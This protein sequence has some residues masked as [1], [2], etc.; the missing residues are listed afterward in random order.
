MRVQSTLALT[1]DLL[2]GNLSCQKR[3]LS[4]RYLVCLPKHLPPAKPNDSATAECSPDPYRACVGRHPC[5]CRCLEPCSWLGPCMCASVFGYSRWTRRVDE[6]SPPSKGPRNAQLVGRYPRSAA[7]YWLA[8]AIDISGVDSPA[9][10]TADSR[11][12]FSL[13][14]ILYRKQ[15]FLFSFKLYIYTER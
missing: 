10:S 9:T 6:E 2:D 11:T 13:G 7:E 14:R 3:R 15:D 5:P 1:K 8:L 12:Y 4:S